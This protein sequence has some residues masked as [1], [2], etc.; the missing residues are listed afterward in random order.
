MKNPQLAYDIVKAMTDVLCKPVTVKIRSGWDANSINCSP[1]WTAS[2]GEQLIA[3]TMPE[4][5]A[6]I[7]ITSYNVCYTKLLRIINKPKRD[8]FVC[9][10]GRRL[11]QTNREPTRM[12][13][14]ADPQ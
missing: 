5:G 4:A 14:V 2:P 7:R 12:T 1:G 13:T 3:L 6:L 11:R 10:S 8:A 9:S